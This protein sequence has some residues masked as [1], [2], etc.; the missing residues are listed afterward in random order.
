MLPATSSGSKLNICKTS[1]TPIAAECGSYPRRQPPEESIEVTADQ[2][3][4]VLDALS[5]TFDY[6][7]VDTSPSL[8]EINLR[9]L[10]RATLILQ[11]TTP[12]LAALKRAKV[13]LGLMRKT[14]QFPDERIKLLLNFPYGMPGVA[15]SEI[16]SSLD[17]SGFLEGSLRSGGRPGGTHRT[18]V[19]RI[20][21]KLALQQEY[22]RAST[23]ALRLTSSSR[24]VISHPMAT[25]NCA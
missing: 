11:M 4:E 3:G 7:V 13:S 12:E 6:T 23:I 17:F 19:C 24:G 1:S 15:V 16:E 14:W 10:E 21:P 25:L 2:V 8:S 22:F 5:R 9:A 20:S 18:P